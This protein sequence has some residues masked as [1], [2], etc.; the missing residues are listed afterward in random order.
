[1][2]VPELEGR[3]LLLTVTAL[4]SLGFMLIG[5]DNGLMGGLVNSPAF[6][7]SFNYPDSK[8]IGVI[9]AIFEGQLLF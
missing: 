7:S 5:Y 1:M 4:T 8:M 9:V 6:G 2:A 3:A